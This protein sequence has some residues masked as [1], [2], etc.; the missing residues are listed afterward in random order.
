MQHFLRKLICVFLSRFDLKVVF[1]VDEFYLTS[2]ILR[3]LD[4]FEDYKD[5]NILYEVCNVSYYIYVYSKVRK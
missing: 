1:C 3:D 5:L 2:F 4:E